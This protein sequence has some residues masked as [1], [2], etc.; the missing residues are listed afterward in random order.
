VTP[1]LRRLYAPRRARVETAADGSPSAVEG[2]AVEAVREEWVVED[3]WWTDRPLRRHYFELVLADGR[4]TTVFR[5]LRS[6]R[7]YRQ[8]A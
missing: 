1:G 2:T 3:R 5:S 6:G 4:D 7:W 8:R